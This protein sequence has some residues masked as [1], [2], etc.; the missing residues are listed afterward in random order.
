MTHYVFE[1]VSY[2]A[3]KNLP[4]PVCG[5]RVRRQR[6]FTNTISPFNLNENGVPRGYAEVFEQVVEKG[7]L[8][9]A[10]DPV[11]HPKCEARDG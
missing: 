7:R 5:K 11:T 1:E 4:C 6:T 9:A 8:W 3:I 10:L 2:T